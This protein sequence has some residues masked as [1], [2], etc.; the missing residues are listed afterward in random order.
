MVLDFV[1]AINYNFHPVFKIS[2]FAFV[3]PGILLSDSAQRLSLTL[4]L[5]LAMLVT[6]L[7]QSFLHPVRC[8]HLKNLIP[9]PLHTWM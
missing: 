1:S 2:R 4:P 8:N 6:S 7:F 5:L 9:S 3:S